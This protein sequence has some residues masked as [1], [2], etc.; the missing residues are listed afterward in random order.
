MDLYGFWIHDPWRPLM[1]WPHSEFVSPYTLLS[2]WSTCSDSDPCSWRSSLFGA[3]QRPLGQGFVKTTCSA[4]AGCVWIQATFLAAFWRRGDLDDN[5][6]VMVRWFGAAMPGSPAWM[7]RDTTGSS[8][9]EIGEGGPCRVAVLDV[10]GI[11]ILRTSSLLPD[12]FFD[13]QHKTLQF[14][15]VWMLFNH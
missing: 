6:A 12:Y 4:I 7:D 1:I 10:H 8:W 13:S 3:N 2:T 15:L 9:G 5:I 14:F 11:L